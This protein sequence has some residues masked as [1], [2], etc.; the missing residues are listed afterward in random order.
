[1]APTR[2]LRRNSSVAHDLRGDGGVRPLGSHPAAPRDRLRSLGDPRVIDVTN[3]AGRGQDRF[4]PASFVT[5]GRLPVCGP[6]LSV[7][8]LDVGAG[9]NDV[10]AL[11]E[12][13]VYLA[14]VV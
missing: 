11:V 6:V 9:R 13:H 3:E 1:M 12:L 8:I 2:S 14:P 5:P 4:R 7:V 10:E